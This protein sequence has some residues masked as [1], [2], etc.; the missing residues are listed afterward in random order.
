MRLEIKKSV[1]RRTSDLSKFFIIVYILLLNLCLVNVVVCLGYYTYVFDKETRALLPEKMIFPEYDKNGEVTN[2]EEVTAWEYTAYVP[3]GLYKVHN[4]FCRVAE[5]DAAVEFL[6]LLA[7]F[8]P[9]LICYRR[10]YT[11]PYLA[12][13]Y[14]IV[15]FV[16]TLFVLPRVCGGRTAW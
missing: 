4:Y 16:I 12:I 2:A 13:A 7:L 3:Q 14:L 1:M 15:L 10:T 9:M 8:L 11:K 5:R 6:V